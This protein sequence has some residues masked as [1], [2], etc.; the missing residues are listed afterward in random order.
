MGQ[1]EPRVPL[2]MTS[3]EDPYAGKVSLPLD[4]PID[5]EATPVLFL[6]T[7][8]PYAGVQAPIGVAPLNTEAT[9][10]ERHPDF[11][12]PDPS[13]SVSATDPILLVGPLP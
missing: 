2:P 10:G 1:Y 6:A 13:A 9:A 12:A 7:E 8:D 4:R 5:A 3:L 11:C